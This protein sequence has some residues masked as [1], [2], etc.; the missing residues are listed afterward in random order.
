M[1]EIAQTPR[2][3]DILADAAD[4]ARAA[5]H[6]WVGVEHVMLAI[7]ADRDA[8]PT[9]VLDRLGID[10]GGAAT[11]ITRTMSTDGYLTPTRRARLLS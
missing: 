6:D 1:D 7:L 3:Q 8:V 4:R 2:L 9:Q 11:E 10:I 5:G